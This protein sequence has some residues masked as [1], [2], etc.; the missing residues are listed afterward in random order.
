MVFVGES[1]PSIISAFED[2]AS[3]AWALS[4]LYFILRV[5][6]NNIA[7]FALT[8]LSIL[9][10]RGLIRLFIGRAWIRRR[11]WWIAQFCLMTSLIV[12]SLVVLNVFAYFHS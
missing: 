5:G 6:P 4:A 7:N 3:C 10:V 9:L 12:K 2:V 1:R 11:F 8:L